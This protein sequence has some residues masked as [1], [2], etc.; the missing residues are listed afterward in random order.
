MELS[1][2]DVDLFRQGALPLPKANSSSEGLVL[3]AMLGRL[4]FAHADYAIITEDTFEAGVSAIKRAPEIKEVHVMFSTIDEAKVEELSELRHLRTLKFAG[5]SIS[6]DLH[7]V[8][9]QNLP[10]CN[11]ERL[12]NVQS[13]PPE[14]RY[15]ERFIDQPLELPR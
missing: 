7:S 2:A 11:V 9:Q 3:D 13:V 5:C 1:E 10:S 15:Y 14:L 4:P 6:D 8:M 12:K